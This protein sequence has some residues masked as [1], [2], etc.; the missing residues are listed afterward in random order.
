MK[1]IV[2]V[3]GEGTRLRPLTY[4][5]PKPL[6]PIA[7]VP[8]LERQLT[9]L[10]RHGIDE[11]VLS[12]GYM[13]DAFEAHFAARRF[14]DMAIRWVVEKE[15]LGT[16]GGIR[17]AAEGIEERVVVCNGDV[18]TDLDVTGLV[19]FHDERSAE[20]TIAL[21]RV[22][23]PSAFGVV[24]TRD[25]G[26]V[27]AFVEKPPAGHAP[28]DW[29]N[30]GT[31][32]LEPSVLHRIPPRLTVSIERETFPRML[33]SPRR[34][35][36]QHSD[37][38]WLDIGTPRKYAEA[39]ADV[40]AGKLGLPPAPGARETSA[41]TWVQGDV[42]ID[43]DARLRGPVL[44]GAGSRIAAGADVAESVV[45]PGATVEAGARVLRSVLLPGARVAADDKAVDV[46]VAPDARLECAG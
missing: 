1:A 28:T 40:L 21:T 12:L 20:A 17:F 23:D 44:L 15:P 9:W 38:Y 13:P 37:A 14:G 30:A 7:N 42:R 35:F 3:G 5:T 32:V 43:P 34:L 2:L 29:I 18:L 8:F 46:V 36:A 24:P 19:R 6:L 33:D 11:A 25:D 4:H 45:G 22:E 16:A 41:G 31:Y 26:E 10:A 39:Q 27:V